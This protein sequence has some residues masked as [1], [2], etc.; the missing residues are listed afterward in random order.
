MDIVVVGSKSKAMWFY[1]LYL[2][3]Y[4]VILEFSLGVQKKTAKKA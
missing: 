3:L 4:V 1:V 2:Y